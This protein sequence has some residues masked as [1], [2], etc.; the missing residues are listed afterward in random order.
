MCRGGDGIVM[1]LKE[2]LSDYWQALII[3]LTTPFIL[4]AWLLLELL[5]YGVTCLFFGNRVKKRWW[6]LYLVP[7]FIKEWTAPIRN[8]RYA[9]RAQTD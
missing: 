8:K 9:Q 3:V 4:L 5:P 2:T 1:M 6:Y 7:R